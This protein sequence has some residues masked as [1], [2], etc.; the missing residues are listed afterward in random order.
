MILPL[1]SLLLIGE[2]SKPITRPDWRTFKR[3]ISETIYIN[4]IDTLYEF[5]NTCALFKLVHTNMH[6]R[7]DLCLYDMTQEELDAFI[8]YPHDKRIVFSN[9]EN[10]CYIVIHVEFLFLL[11]LFV[12]N[13][14]QLKLNFSNKLILLIYF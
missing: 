9:V 14:L 13:L 8:N 11:Y 2:Y 5:D 1:R 6:I 4:D 7:I 3:N 12:C 10:V